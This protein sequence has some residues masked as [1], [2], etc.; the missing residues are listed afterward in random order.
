MTVTL[1]AILLMGQPAPATRQQPIAAP[2]TPEARKASYAFGACTA[3]N[4]TNKASKTLLTDFR[5]DAYRNS[6]H[7]LAEFN[8]GC[9]RQRWI[10]SN[11]LLYAGAIAERLLT[12][13]ATPL[14]VR[15]ARAALRPI[16]QPL[17]PSDQV[18]FC[19]A[20]SV[21][22][23]VA[24]LFSTAVASA[25]EQVAERKLD[26]IF[27]RCAGSTADVIMTDDARRAVI[28][29]A[30]FRAVTIDQSAPETVR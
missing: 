6:L 2:S 7:N 11:S 12:K 16:A 5:T 18:A 13:D 9:S 26:G 20:Y 21:P 17:T 10:R 15:L 4:S 29:T 25:E 1:F 19:V 22:D 14:N 24:G 28:A 30:A 8:R 23:D 3:D 27:Q